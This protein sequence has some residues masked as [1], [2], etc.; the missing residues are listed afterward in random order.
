MSFLKLVIPKSFQ[1]YEQ[2]YLIAINAF[3]ISST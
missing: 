2:S 3:I 1:Y